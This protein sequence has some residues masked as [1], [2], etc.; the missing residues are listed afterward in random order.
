MTNRE[1]TLPK[2]Q[3][4]FGSKVWCVSKDVAIKAAIDAG[5]SQ[6]YIEAF[7][8]DYNNL[9]MQAFKKILSQKD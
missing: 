3:T 1:K 8:E 6:D 9:A 7:D 5:Y 4:I 2:R